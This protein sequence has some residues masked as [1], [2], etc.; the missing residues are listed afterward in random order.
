MTVLT[1]ATASYLDTVY[2]LQL[3]YSQI[4]CTM[5]VRVI[6]WQQEGLRNISLSIHNYIKFTLH[7]VAK[8]A[9]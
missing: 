9:S 1:V 5:Y 6:A 4:F 8:I 3:L 2:A 7:D